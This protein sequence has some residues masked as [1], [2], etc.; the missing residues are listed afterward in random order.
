[1]WLKYTRIVAIMILIL[2]PMENLKYTKIME[3][4]LDMIGFREFTSND[5]NIM[6]ANELV[7]ANLESYSKIL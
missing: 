1:M 2:R 6:T 7:L 3:R 5:V 4:I